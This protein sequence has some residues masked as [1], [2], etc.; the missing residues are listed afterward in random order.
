M[1]PKP[2]EILPHGKGFIFV[3]E[4]I[5]IEKGKYIKTLKEVSEK[6]FWYHD[7]FPSNPIMPGV[8][9]VEAMAQSSALLVLI[10]F[11]EFR[12]KPFVLA[13]IKEA[14]FKKPIIPPSK[15]IIKSEFESRKLNIWSF[16]CWAYVDDKEAAYSKIIAANTK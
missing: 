16:N 12:G 5:E 10:S 11:P 9:L 8:I 14:R 2:F 6:D 7:H 15:I 13:G 3:D 4:I 1:F